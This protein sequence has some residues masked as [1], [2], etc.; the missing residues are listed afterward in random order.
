VLGFW[1]KKEAKLLFYLCLKISQI[2]SLEME[3]LNNLEEDISKD[4]R[5]AFCFSS[6]GLGILKSCEDFSKRSWVK[7][8]FGAA[9]VAGVGLGAATLLPATQ[10]VAAFGLLGSGGV[11]KAMW[12]SEKLQTTITVG[13][14]KDIFIYI[15]NN[16]DAEEKP[17]DS[18]PTS[19]YLKN[20]FKR[21]WIIPLPAPQAPDVVLE[22]I[23]PAVHSPAELAEIQQKQK[24]RRA[25]AEIA[26]AFA[27]GN[28]LSVVGKKPE[29]IGPLLDHCT[30]ALRGHS[31]DMTYLRKLRRGL[32]SVLKFRNISP[33]P[34]RQQSR[35]G[36]RI[37]TKKKIQQRHQTNDRTRRKRSKGKMRNASAS[38]SRPTRAARKLRAEPRTKRR[39]LHQA[40]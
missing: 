39:R 7:R 18:R 11:I 28:F 4:V 12:N 22:E 37:K 27:T 25:D 29:F 38:R 1:N 19:Q 36:Q 5:N 34:S 17:T 20:N 30:G 6:N 16:L 24:E 35:G 33:P 9:G 14:T 26:N 13:T 31:E 10:A 21:D 32:Q 8:L 40:T 3:K 23:L 2:Q 15:T